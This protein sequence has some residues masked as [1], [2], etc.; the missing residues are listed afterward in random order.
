MSEARYKVYNRNRFI[1]SFRQPL[2]AVKFLTLCGSP[3]MDMR[4]GYLKSGILW[5]YA[6]NEQMGWPEIERELEFRIA[7]WQ[8][9]NRGIG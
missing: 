2:D 5:T 6:P 9:K 3:G 1:A 4:I 8:R 7:D